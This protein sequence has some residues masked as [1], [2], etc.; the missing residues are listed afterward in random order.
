MAIASSP[1]LARQALEAQERQRM[2]PP[3]LAAQLEKLP[4]GLILLNVDSDPKEK[5]PKLLAGLPGELQKGLSLA[6]AQSQM[7]AQPAAGT[8]SRPG[9]GSGSSSAGAGNSS[10]T[11]SFP[12]AYGGAA[13][14]QVSRLRMLPR[15]TKSAP[16]SNRPRPSSLRPMPSRDSSF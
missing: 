3:D 8:A 4:P 2:A 6:L 9:S 1:D 7:K 16:V 10:A 14:G 5:L 15:A 13:A 12:G 11:P